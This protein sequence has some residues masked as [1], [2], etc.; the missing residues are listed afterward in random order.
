MIPEAEGDFRPN[1]DEGEIELGEVTMNLGRTGIMALVFMAGTATGLAL[2]KEKGVAPALFQGREAKAAGTALL[3]VAER[4]AGKG[5]WE[6]IGVGRVYYLSGDKARGQ[7]LFDRVLG[8]KP[9]RSDWERVAKVYAEAGEW[10]KAEPLF[11]KVV[12]GDPK[13]DSG[14]SLAGA[15]YNLNGDRAKAEELFARCFQLKPDDVWDTVNAAASYLG[16]RPD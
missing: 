4:Q 16:V 1:G 15:Y 13:D 6:L 2:A 12:A 14:L 8:G 9:E 10:S 5:S 3:E 7:A 11:Q